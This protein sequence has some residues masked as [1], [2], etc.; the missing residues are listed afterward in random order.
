MIL[1]LQMHEMA[2]KLTAFCRPTLRSGRVVSPAAALARAKADYAAAF[3]AEH[4][5]L[6]NEVR[7]YRLYLLYEAVLRSER[8][9]NRAQ[10]VVDEAAR[11]P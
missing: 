10:R 7:G 9:V 2:F 6:H 1:L 11:R 3:A 5:A 8:A 4:A